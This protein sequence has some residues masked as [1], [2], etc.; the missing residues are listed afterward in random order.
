MIGSVNEEAP[1]FDMTS[2]IAERSAHVIGGMFDPAMPDRVAVISLPPAGSS[3]EERINDG[4]TSY[5]VRMLSRADAAAAI[6]MLPG[7][8]LMARGVLTGAQRERGKIEVVT[9]D[10]ENTA[11]PVD[12]RK[13][14]TSEAL[15]KRA[16]YVDDWFGRWFGALRGGFD[17]FMIEGQSTSGS[18]MRSR[19]C[20][21]CVQWSTALTNAGLLANGVDLIALRASPP[22]STIAPYCEACERDIATVLGHFRGQGFTIA[23]FEL[24]AGLDAERAVALYERTYFPTGRQDVADLS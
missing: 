20:P 13:M 1:P 24:R 5:P 17:G 23:P 12:V 14:W 18:L 10:I 3:E 7:Q 21:L 22:S 19:S 2:H 9:I 16:E 4:W 8:G 11:A 15:S 6:A